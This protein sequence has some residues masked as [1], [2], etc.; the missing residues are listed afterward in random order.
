MSKRIIMLYLIH[1]EDSFRSWQYLLK[2][3]EF[4]QKDAPAFFDYDFS[5]KAKTPSDLSV[6][7]DILK[8]KTL[9][10]GSRLILIKNI[11]KNTN[12]QF[13]N[14]FLKILK[15]QKVELAK[16]L[17]II[18]Y[19]N[20]KI[21]SNSL[22]KW[23]KQKAKGDKEFPLLKSGKL[24]K[25]ITEQEQEFGLRLSPEARQLLAN[26]FF[27]D[28]GSIYHALKKLSL[29]KKGL[30]DR[31]LLEESL[32]LPV[33]STIFIFLDYLIS[34]NDKQTFSFLEVLINQGLHPL[35]IL[36]MIVFQIRNLLILKESSRKPA[37]MHYYTYS[38]LLPLSKMIPAQILKETFQDLLF[39]DQKIKS[40]NIEAK[41]GLEMFLI[42]FFHK[43][44]N[45]ISQSNVNN[46]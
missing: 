17:M 21:L 45:T 37:S 20:D 2:V 1:G 13:R 4:Y 19:E 38:K 27:S 3:K 22:Q 40:G 10:S 46:F 25:W 8:S 6:L 9:F 7:N 36:K 33:S 30:I 12:I 32:F 44:C 11:F 41:I 26:S 29:I 28:T 35:F 34:S 24:T 15:A 42:D 31:K 18:F 43:R 23:V 14:D 16:D 39:C 5:D